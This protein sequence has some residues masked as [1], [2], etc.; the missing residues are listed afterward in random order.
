MI[1]LKDKQKSHI[2]QCLG[3]FKKYQLLYPFLISYN[4]YNAI[5]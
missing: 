5:F 4:N 3:S 2:L 1:Y